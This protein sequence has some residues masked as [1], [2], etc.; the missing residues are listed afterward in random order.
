MGYSWSNYLLRMTVLVS[1]DLFN[2]SGEQPLFIHIFEVHSYTSSNR[3]CEQIQLLHPFQSAF[4]KDL[5]L[6]R[7][8]IGHLSHM[9]L[10]LLQ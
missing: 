1:L 10:L 7:S 6:E 4:F 8:V 9:I 5:L 2:V 3:L